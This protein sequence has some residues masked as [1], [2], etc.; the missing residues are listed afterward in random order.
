MSLVDKIMQQVDAKDATLQYGMPGNV[1]EV[2]SALS[3]F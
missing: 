2:F 3:D 1:T